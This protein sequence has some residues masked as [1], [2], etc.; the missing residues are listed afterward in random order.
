MKKKIFALIG[1][2]ATISFVFISCKG[3]D[4]DR[5]E[6]LKGMSSLWAYRYVGSL[7]SYYEHKYSSPTYREGVTTIN[8]T[9]AIE[10]FET[11]V[12]CGDSLN[13]KSTIVMT[14]SVLTVTTDGYRIADNLTAHIFTVDPGIINYNGKVHIDFYLTDGMIPWAWT[15]VTITEDNLY[16]L[17]DSNNYD[18][19]TLGWY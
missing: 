3:I 11:G 2:I 16:S 6:S 18:H 15:E 12:S 5:D 10:E 7:F 17:Y 1:F 4:W 8:D 14:D 13:I 19:V 9:I